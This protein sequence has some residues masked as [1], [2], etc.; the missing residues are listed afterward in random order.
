MNETT[1][2][3]IEKAVAEHIAEKAKELAA[4]SGN[5]YISWFFRAVATVAVALAAYCMSNCSFK[6]ENLDVK[7]YPPA[8]EEL[9]K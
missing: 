6:A 9:V 5:K 8:I 7:I 3:E 1:K 4:K 2:K